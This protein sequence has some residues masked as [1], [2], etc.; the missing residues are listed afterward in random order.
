M[1][2]LIREGDSNLANFGQLGGVYLKG[3]VNS[4]T[5][6]VSSEDYKIVAIQ[7]LE[8]N[9]QLHSD[10]LSDNAFAVVSGDPWV[11]SH[12]GIG[13]PNPVGINLKAGV[14][15][16]G[17]WKKVKITGADGATGGAIAYMA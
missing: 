6:D 17:R 7:I 5:V 12:T 8:D 11:P 16:F 3:D 9:T 13:F 4:G 15:I 14:I 1:S 2:N 10:T